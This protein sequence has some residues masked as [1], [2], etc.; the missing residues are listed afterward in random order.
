MDECLFDGE[1]VQQINIEY[2]LNKE[3]ERVYVCGG[4][5]G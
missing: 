4:G 3:G 1:F 2:C 5:T